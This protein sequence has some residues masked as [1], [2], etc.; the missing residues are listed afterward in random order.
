VVVGVARDVDAL[1]KVLVGLLEE[2]G[3]LSL[4]D[5]AARSGASRPTVAGRIKSLVADGVLRVS[6]LVNTFEVRGITTALVGLSLDGFKLDQK[7][8][9]IAALD[10]VSWAAVV[11]GRYDIIVEVVTD[12]GMTGLY[13]VLS[14][15]LGHIGGISSTEMF[16]VMKARNKWTL[17]PP[18]MRTAWM[19]RSEGR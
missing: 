6:G 9:Q 14:E 13:N 16:V 2:E 1:D 7:V 15:S 8:E 4:A 11:T 5:T 17:L 3:R 12:E 19:G 10:E 18:G